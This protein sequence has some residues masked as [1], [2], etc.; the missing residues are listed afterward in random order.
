V[1]VKDKTDSLNIK[2]LFLEEWIT[3]VE[4]RGDDRVWFKTESGK[5]YVL[6]ELRGVIRAD[7]RVVR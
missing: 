7:L 2:S 4:E 6:C 3:E 5:L 1:G